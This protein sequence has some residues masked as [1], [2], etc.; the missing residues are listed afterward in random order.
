[1]NPYQELEVPKDADK[2]TIKRAYRRKA[3]KH[4]PDREGG[5]TSK[6]Q[7]VKRAYEVLSD[8]ALRHQYDHTGEIP[9]GDTRRQQ[10]LQ[11]LA[12]LVLHLIERVADVDTFDLGSAI[13]SAI[14]DGIANRQRE[15]KQVVAKMNKFQKALARLAKKTDEPDAIAHVLTVKIQQLEDGIKVADA[16]TALGAEMLK[17]WD[18]YEF[19]FDSPAK[20]EFSR[21]FRS[22]TISGV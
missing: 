2:A 4:H 5:D 20:S 16:D 17:L 12:D 22:T 10:A 15:R 11:G 9:D 3:S 13:K 7:L 18:E 21:Y 14:R 8:P 1:M 6:F 19:K